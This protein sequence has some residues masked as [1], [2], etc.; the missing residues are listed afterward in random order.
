MPRT[1]DGFMP[2]APV[3]PHLAPHNRIVPAAH[4][5]VKPL[6]R[7]V[8]LPRPR[9]RPEQQAKPAVAKPAIVPAVT[10]APTPT[11][12]VAAPRRAYA[13]SAPVVTKRRRGVP[14]RFHLPLIII[15][16]ILAGIFAQSAV[17][18][19]LMVVAYGIAALIWR[20]ASRTTFTLALLSMVATT[21]LLVVR[22]N[23]ALAQNFATYTF[24][25]LVVGVITL[26]GELKKE[27]GR[28]YSNRKNI[29]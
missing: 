19:E 22:G 2:R 27:G 12:S 17:F 6:S 24:L 8:L 1:I 4:S 20:I 29:T 26:T 3:L 25:L 28:V 15:G 9:L 13:R 7:A 5:P 16:A 18:G 11:A 14:E 10:P 21:L 23:V